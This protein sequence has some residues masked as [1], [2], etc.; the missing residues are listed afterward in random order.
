MKHSCRNIKREDWSQSK[1]EVTVP[2]VDRSFMDVYIYHISYIKYIIY[3]VYWYIHVSFIHKCF[4]FLDTGI[5]CHELVVDR[6]LQRRVPHSHCIVSGLQYSTQLAIKVNPRSR[7]KSQAGQQI[8]YRSSAYGDRDDHLQ[9]Y[10]K[11][12]QYRS[13]GRYWIRLLV[14]IFCKYTL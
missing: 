14:R 2:V 1:N 3:I 6:R 11:C 9:L 8:G 13:I 10:R 4:M 5:S 7:P 12:V